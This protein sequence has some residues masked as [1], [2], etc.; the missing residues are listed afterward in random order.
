[1]EGNAIPHSQ[2]V[3]GVKLSDQRTELPGKEVRHFQIASL[4]PDQRS[5]LARSWPV[6]IGNAGES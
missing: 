4:D 3:G 2:I 6:K 1:M 5:G